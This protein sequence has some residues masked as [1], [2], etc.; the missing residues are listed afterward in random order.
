MNQKQ[1]KSPLFTLTAILAALWLLSVAC[2]LPLMQPVASANVAPETAVALTVAAMP[3]RTPL[4]AT[5]APPAAT[6][7]QAPPPATPT[8]VPP[9]AGTPVA[10]GEVALDPCSLLAPEEA[11]AILSGETLK[12][13]QVN[14]G[15]CIYTEAS[16]G[17]HVVSAYALQGQAALNFWSGR[18]F[19]LSAFGLVID[20][21]TLE[22]IKVWDA[23]GD[24]KSIL[25]KLSGMSAGNPAFVSRT[26][27]GPGEIA[28]WVWKDFS[29]GV[30]QDLLIWVTGNTV[31]G[32]DLVHGDN[33]DEATAFERV[34]QAAN[35]IAG[36]IPPVF[37]L[38]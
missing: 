35:N 24:H 10:Q 28:W 31:A 36:R 16:Q 5:Q 38:K 37:H 30:R 13:P 32:I 26:L 17:V 27:E 33:I 22:Q 8:L 29:N 14:G 23:A 34:S 9:L 25:I 1:S 2:N 3:T 21:P 6:A 20:Q 11:A 12:A 4:P 15:S 7:T 18:V 19:Q